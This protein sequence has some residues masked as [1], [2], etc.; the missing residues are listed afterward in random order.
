MR[1]IFTILIVSL[2]GP[3]H[4][5]AQ[6]EDFKKIE[7]RRFK[8]LYEMNDS[9]YRSEQPSRKG[10]KELEALGIK[11]AIS[12]R[13]AKDDTKKAKG[14]SMQLEHIP[15]R[16]KELTE[17]DIVEVLRVIKD[18]PKPLLI[19]CYHGSDRTGVISAAYRVVFE[20]WTKERAIEEM[21]YPAFGYHEKWYP[22]LVDFITDLDV[23]GIKKELE[24]N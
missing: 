18:A 13:R 6:N 3:I 12:F 17:S 10:F 15:L 9:I 23:E 8:N 20:D 4:L 11:T 14:T 19:H 16:S 7:S 5:K 24:I 21:R 1:L 2:T 22:F